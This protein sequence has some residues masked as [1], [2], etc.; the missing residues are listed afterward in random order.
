MKRQKHPEDAVTFI[1][2]NFSSYYSR[3]SRCCRKAVQ[4]ISELAVVF[5]RIEVVK[6]SK[7]NGCHEWLESNTSI[8]PM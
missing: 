1:N 7:S 6:Q 2:H 5:S 8:S 3:L 4:H